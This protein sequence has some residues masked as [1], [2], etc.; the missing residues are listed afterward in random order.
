VVAVGLVTF[1][2]GLDYVIRY[3]VRAWRHKRTP[4]A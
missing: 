4:P 2:S 1:V 3:G